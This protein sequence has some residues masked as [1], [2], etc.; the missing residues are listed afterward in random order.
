M[1][2]CYRGCC[3][4]TDWSRYYRKLFQV[5]TDLSKVIS[6]YMFGKKMCF[7]VCTLEHQAVLNVLI[8]T[9]LLSFPAQLHVLL[10]KASNNN[11]Y[12]LLLLLLLLY[13]L[14]GGLQNPHRGNS[15]SEHRNGITMTTT[16]QQL[17]Q[18]REKRN[19]L[20]QNQFITV[21]QECHSLYIQ[22]T[23]HLG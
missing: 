7:H 2:L 5:S 20:P 19:I 21:A 14:E 22:N 9:P 17:R 11:C 18:P 4:V 1:G 12:W 10:Q 6:G 13:C 15:F 16:N 3:W 23:W 8:Y